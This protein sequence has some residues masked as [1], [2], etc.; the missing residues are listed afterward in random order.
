[1][2]NKFDSEK[3]H[4]LAAQFKA[5]HYADEML[6]FVNAWDC[7]SAKIVEEAGYP[8][9]A[10]TS[11]GISWSF[12]YKDGEHIDPDLMILMHSR[13]CASV[14]VPVTADIECGYYSDNPERFS[15]FIGDMVEAG[16][17]GINLEDSNTREKKWNEVSFQQRLIRLAKQAGEERGVDLFVNARVDAMD[18][19][20]GS[21]QDK[22]SASIERAKAYQEA[23]ADGIFVPF[24]S[25]IKIV[26]GVKES[27]QLPLNILMNPALDIKGLKDIKVNRLTVGGKP[28]TASMGML[29]HMAEQMKTDEYWDL[30]YTDYPTY[31][32]MNSWFE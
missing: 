23:G 11:S 8:A 19:V 26:A 6:I 17:V 31:P 13:I 5:L 9:I 1:M 2:E 3:Q 12:G 4:N 20:K 7:V 16:V 32:E 29:K 21:D 18:Y 14:K 30:L 22:I 15:K 10:T 28:K 25:D 24:I 27:I